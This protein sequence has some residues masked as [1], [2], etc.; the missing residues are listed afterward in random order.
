M[1]EKVY[2]WKRFW[3]SR[4]AQVNLD[5]R[6]YLYDPES[7]YRHLPN[8]E[9]VK[10]EAIADIPCLILLGEPGIG[11]SQ[12][13]KNLLK[14]TG[15]TIKPPHRTLER[16]LRSCN[17]LETYLIQ[18]QDFIDWIN[19]EHR[20]YLF[21]D[22]LDEGML[23]VT[24][25]A[26]QLVDE[27]SQDKY[28][29]KLDRLY[30][31]IAGRTAILSRLLEEGL[32][33]LWA[34][35]L[36]IYE[37][38]P[39]SKVDVEN[40]AIEEGV[41]SQHF[42]SEAWSKTFVSL[43]IKP[44]TLKFLINIYK[45]NGCQFSSDQTLHSLYLKGCKLLCEETNPA[46]ISAG[47]TGILE[48][49]QRLVIAARI[50]AITIFTNRFA[51]WTEIDQGE[52]PMEDVLIE[53]LIVGDVT[54]L[55]IK[56]VR[57]VLEN[58]QLFSSRGSSNQIGWA[59]QSYA[60]FLAA[61][62]LKQHNVS[63]SQILKL[64]I[65]PSGKVIPQLRETAAWLASMM[66]EIFQ[67]VVRTNPDIL[68]NSS[69]AMTDDQ[70]RSKLVESLL[71]LHEENKLEMFRFRRYENLRHPDLSAQLKTYISD[72]TKNQS[73]RY[74][75]INIAIDCKQKDIQS[76]LLD[77][78]LDK[79]QPYEIRK[80]SACAV[81][82][83]GDENTIKQLK[84]LAL[85]DIK[86]DPDDAL[87]GYGFRAIWPQ[88]ITTLD[89][90]SHLSPP[91]T[92]GVIG[93]IYQDFIATEFT[94]HLE[95]SELPIALEWLEKLPNRHSLDYPFIDLVD[96]VILKAWQNLD[97]PNVIKAFAS[98]AM[99]RLKRSEGILGARPS[100]WFVLDSEQ[101]ND[102]KIEP[103]IKNSD[104]KRRRLIE[105]MV[106][107]ITESE[108]NLLW[109]TGIVCSKDI[110]WI[111][112]KAISSESDGIARVWAE[113]LN[114]S[115][116]YH[117][118]EWKNTKH[119]DAL[120]DACSIKAV[121][122]AKFECYITPIEL[123]SE[124]A[125]Q[126]KADYLR[127]KD[128][129][130]PPEPTS[131]TT[132]ELKQKVVSILEK[133][134]SKQPELWWQIPKEM[135]LVSNES[136]Y[137][138]HYRAD[139]DT[140]I[141]PG[142]IEADE[143]IR[144]RVIKAAKAYLLL[145]KLDIQE[146]ESNNNLSLSDAQLAGCRA[147]HLLFQQDLEFI[148]KI[149]SEVWIKWM[150]IIFK[151]IFLSNGCKNEICQKI[152]RAAYKA[153][154]NEFIEILVDLITRDNNQSD[155]SYGNHIYEVIGKMLNECIAN[156]VFYKIQDQNKDLN[157]KLLNKL[158]LDLSDR[159]IEEAR[160]IALSFLCRREE[161][162]DK[163]IVA[164]RMLTIHANDSSWS[165]LWPIVQQ[166]PTF[167]H[168]VFE[169]IALRV[170]HQNTMQQNLNEEHLANLYI[171]LV[172]QFPESEEVKSQNNKG[173][174]FKPMESIDG[175]KR[176]RS[177][178]LQHLQSLGSI[179]A[180]EALQKMVIEL[181]DQKED[182]QQKLLEVESLI[183]RKTWKYP[184]PGEILQLVT[185]KEPSNLDLDNHLSNINR[186]IQQ[187]ADEPKIDQSIHIVKS[188]VNGGVGNIDTGKI[189]DSGKRFDWK[190]WLTIIISS[191]GVLGTLVSIAVNG[192]F[193][194]EV[195]KF[196]HDRN[197]PPKVEKKI[198]M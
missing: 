139:L 76:H 149:H 105:T 106:L 87:K 148:S 47:Q 138:N 196:L 164:A 33:R 84:P 128:V 79:T 120:L 58:T 133:V 174:I 159:T 78:T 117:N 13:M 171:F 111:I 131:L 188:K 193:T 20:L 97:E 110:L 5:D 142:W 34:E 91:T 135:T 66:P 183:R 88:H 38:A 161:V 55:A 156:L 169:A 7:E 80:I 141:F 12:E 140:T 10:L 127:Y 72:S 125:D 64:I 180:S 19:G 143:D 190:F 187:M 95:L 90:L 184:N 67:E 98:I 158:L 82:E 39:L 118:L 62:C 77:I 29:D 104:D 53:Q 152:V 175:I 168:E 112:E 107:L 185:K 102:D 151:S 93:S 41:D 155:T 21:L 28:S 123:N 3:C 35:K 69:I 49:E 103:L 14:Y 23:T 197:T 130:R 71:K 146:Y 45:H 167:G 42:L 100:K 182:L 52:V 163:R 48:P 194:E 75:A 46:R 56:A 179:E 96:S 108:E 25:L 195:K 9:L 166:D 60:E 51:I 160:D 26:I 109:L 8:P 147:L 83:I 157:A 70:S 150:H 57:E 162:R 198:E 153:A 132:P 145:G 63:T 94:K 136:H 113:A 116:N 192:V 124:I 119:I 61:W 31:R 114:I 86:D 170:G 1:S 101:N 172:Q 44:V 15:E 50:A 30:L 191:I 73:S 189:A 115:L 178:I 32:Q 11:K 126:A 68:L 144:S 99:S 17:N 24:N 18:N 154:Q 74:V 177:N 54:K 36:A 40:A 89:L 173:T 176:W 27:F 6:G 165:T 2:N 81:C 121:I 85:N 16:N 92:T 181:P 137:N 122:K 186:E 22:S 4:T 129:L 43:A 59:H 134:E 37:L 65:H